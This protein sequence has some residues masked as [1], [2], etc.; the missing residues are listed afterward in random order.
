MPATSA[1]NS[2]RTRALS[3]D[4]AIG[5]GPVPDYWQQLDDIGPEE[6]DADPGRLRS[7]GFEA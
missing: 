3:H 6:C 5:T 7:A 2:V 1:V 4:S